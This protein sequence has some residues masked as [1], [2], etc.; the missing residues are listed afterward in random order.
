[1]VKKR[2]AS[3]CKKHKNWTEDVMFSNESTFRL[4]NPRAQ[5]VRRPA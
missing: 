3:F 4:I 1:M 2:I 5:M